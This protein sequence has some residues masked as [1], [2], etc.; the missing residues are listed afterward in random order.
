MSS[1]RKEQTRLSRRRFI[2]EAAAG[3]AAAVG[4]GLLAGC[5]QTPQIVKETVEIPVEVIKKE[6]VVSPS[7]AS[8]WELVNP[9]GVVSIEPMELAPR[10]TS[11]EGKT[12]GLKWNTK[13]NGDLF[14]DRIAE[15]LEENVPGVKIVKFYE[16]EPSTVPQSATHD[17]AKRKAQIIAGYKPDIVIGSQCD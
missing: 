4:A 16:V 15:L 14:L 1:P 5:S 12:V 9:E 7:A 6:T 17:D 10:I 11:L 13:P 8:Q 3:T 2:R